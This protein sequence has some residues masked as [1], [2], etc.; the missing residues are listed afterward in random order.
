MTLTEF[1]DKIIIYPDVANINK[2]DKDTT[3]VLIDENENSKHYSFPSILSELKNVQ[4]ENKLLRTDIY[5]YLEKSTHNFSF[6]I[7]KIAKN[8]I[9]TAYN[10]RSDFFAI[11]YGI[12]S[13]LSNIH[14]DSIWSIKY[15]AFAFEYLYIQK[16]A[17]LKRYNFHNELYLFAINILDNQ[18]NIRESQRK[19][20]KLNEELNTPRARKYFQKAEAGGLIC[21][22]STGYE[23]ALTK[24]CGSLAQLAYFCGRVYCPDNIGVLPETALDKLFGVSR[25]GA[26]LTQVNNAKKPQKWRQKIDGIFE[27]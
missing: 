6:E 27:D 3:I 23:W 4:H 10:K 26:A 19:N 13:Y 5:N 1:I 14:E 24:G 20:L 2:I 25:I 21:E 8:D 11:L 15:K 16:E 12:E 17:T 18:I 9:I 22:T 7:C